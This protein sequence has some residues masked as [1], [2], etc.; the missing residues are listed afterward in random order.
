MFLLRYL[1]ETRQKHTLKVVTE[2]GKFCKEEEMKDFMHVHTAR[3]H[4][5]EPCVP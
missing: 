4:R 3:G 1:D 2:F 5:K